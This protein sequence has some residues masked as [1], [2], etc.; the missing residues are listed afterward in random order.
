M[1]KRSRELF[2]D[3]FARYPSLEVCGGDILGA[4]ELLRACFANGGKLLLCGNGGS[5]ADCGHIVGELMK[6]FLLKRPVGEDFGQRLH[7]LYPDEA[8]ALCGGLQQ[9]L[10]A[11]S[12]PGWAAL[13]TA[14][15]N[16]VDP[17]MVFAQQVYGLCR[18]GD[19]VMAISTSGNSENVVNAVEI[20]KALHCT[21]VGLTGEKESRLSGLCDV[22]VRVPAAET[23]KVQ[24]LHLPVYHTLCAMLEAEF[25][26]A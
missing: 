14:F 9:A 20:T 24:E 17:G 11:V 2:D 10:P 4:F 6:G 8:A 13:N 18:E 19:V 12:L 22:T 23:F 25:F 16:D 7:D 26:S 5:A 21:A 3:L 15:A 1:K